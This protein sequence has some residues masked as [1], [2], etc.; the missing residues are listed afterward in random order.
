MPRLQRSVET[1]SLTRVLL[2]HIAGKVYI[3]P[4]SPLVYKLL[5]SRFQQKL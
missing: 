1:K 3:P 4:L 5:L 2:A